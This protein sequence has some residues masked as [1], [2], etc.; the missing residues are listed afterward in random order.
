MYSILADS[1]MKHTDCWT[2]S[3]EEL[4]KDDLIDQLDDYLQKN[5]TRLSGDSAFEP[6]YSTRRPARPRESITAGALS[7]GA[8]EIKA[9]AKR[10]TKKLAKAKADVEY[11]D[12]LEC[13]Q[14]DTTMLTRVR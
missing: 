14:R 3:N 11:V 8:E 7:D 13:T 5:S 6:Y 1:V 9:V 4:R 10:A 2:Y 12:H